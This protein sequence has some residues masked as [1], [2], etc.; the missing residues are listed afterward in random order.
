MSPDDAPVES[1]A[2]MAHG[3]LICSIIVDSVP[4]IL[5]QCTTQLVVILTVM[6]L[7]RESPEWLA[8]SSLGALVYNVAGLMLTVAPNLAMDSVAP[9]A[10]GG[11]RFV[12][13]GLAAQ[14]SV[15]TALLFLTPMAIVWFYAERLLMALGQPANA[16]RL[17]TTFV[18][19][20]IPA[21][22]ISAI[23]EASR[24]F[25]YAQDVSRPPL[26][27]ALF[28]LVLHPLW[29]ELL[30]RAFGF[31]G[32]PLALLV[33]HS[34][35]CVG[36]IS[37]C[38]WRKPHKPGTWPG[39]RLRRLVSDRRACIRFLTLS[40]AALGSLSE[41]IFWEFVCFRVGRFGPI[42]LAANGVAYSL[43]PLLYMVPL[44]LSIG[45]ANAVGRK[46]GA[47]AIAECK[48]LAAT[49]LALGV[50]I[51]LTLS[52]ST[53]AARPLI[54]RLYTQSDDVVYI[55]EKLWPWLC[56]DLAFDNSFA[57]LSSL[58]RGLGLTRRS[59]AC[60]VV[61]LWPLG[62]PL[63][64]FGAASV[65]EVWRLMPIIYFT[66]DVTQIGCFTCASWTKLAESV[67]LEASLADGCGSSSTMTISGSS[68]AAPPTPSSSGK[69]VAAAGVEVGEL[70]S[71]SP[72]APSPA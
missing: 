40:L 6:R 59:A 64:I 30:C 7:G 21:L 20:L 33:T 61:C 44:G 35:M 71:A 49:T 15:L 31:V 26:Y 1:D 51:I 43:L 12:D 50:T 2:T 66:L 63:I 42:Q 23:F 9:Q 32:G 37:L 58:N 5:V 70:R 16:A 22:P 27:A 46:L 69:G 19:A 13:V 18:H 47:G 14:R 3:K 57:L 24:K 11:G 53:Y 17:A 25:L 65:L 36:L 48:R 10:F 45:M 54:F 56:I 41:W 34:T 28:A 4:M 60:I 39:I 29:L 38:A 8:G 72:P 67:Q 62:V 55:A 52:A 68:S